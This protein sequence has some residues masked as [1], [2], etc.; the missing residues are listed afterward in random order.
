MEGQADTYNIL[1]TRNGAPPIANDNTLSGMMSEE[2][3][4]LHEQQQPI[5]A[6]TGFLPGPDGATLMTLPQ[7]LVSTRTTAHTD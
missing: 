1:A 3:M 7:C 6:G 5:S 4:S 2:N